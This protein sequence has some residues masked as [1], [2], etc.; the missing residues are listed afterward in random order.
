M[1]ETNTPRSARELALEAEI[2]S[3]KKQLSTDRLTGTDSILVLEQEMRRIELMA[4]RGEIGNVAVIFFDVDDF[5]INQ[6]MPGRGHA[7]GD[8]A[9]KTVAAAAV[10]STRSTDLVVRVGGD[11]YVVLLP[12]ANDAEAREIS[13]RITDVVSRTPVLFENRQDYVGITSGTAVYPE[14]PISQLIKVADERMIEIKASRKIG[15]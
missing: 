7:W 5:K 11:E 10:D 15:R 8:E 14:I 4:A 12:G 13:Q 9:L 1:A 2:T 6:E 3:L